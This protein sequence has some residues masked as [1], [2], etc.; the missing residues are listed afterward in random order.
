MLSSQK[1]HYLWRIPLGSDLKLSGL[2]LPFPHNTHLSL[3]S[4]TRGNIYFSALW[5]SNIIQRYFKKYSGSFI[6]D[7]LIHIVRKGN[8]EFTFSRTL[9]TEDLAWICW[10]ARAE[11]KQQPG[12]KVVD[13][14]RRWETS[15][16]RNGTETSENLGIEVGEKRSGRDICKWGLSVTMVGSVPAGALITAFFLSR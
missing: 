15:K 14:R 6:F 5:C 1:F 8:L 4:R 2:L 13:W 9:I 16:P 7:I 12:N 11:T 3:S 10:D